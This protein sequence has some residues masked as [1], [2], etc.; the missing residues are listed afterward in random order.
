MEYPA[1]AKLQPYLN[2]AQTL[3]AQLLADYKEATVAPQTEDIDRYDKGRD[4]RLSQVYTI[5]DAML[6]MEGMPE[7]QQAAKTVVSSQTET[8]SYFFRQFARYIG[9]YV[10]LCSVKPSND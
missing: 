4:T 5:N 6:K 1:P 8:D 9:N 7:K 3:V 2:D 10:Y